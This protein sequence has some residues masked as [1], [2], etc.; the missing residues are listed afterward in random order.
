MKGRLKLSNLDYNT[1]HPVLFTA[2]HPVVQV[3]LEKAHQDNLYE[4]TE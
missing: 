3:L 4:G 1:K 2:K